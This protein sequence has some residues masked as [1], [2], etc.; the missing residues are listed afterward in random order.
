[1]QYYN[2]FKDSAKLTRESRLLSFHHHGVE[3]IRFIHRRRVVLTP[4]SH[5]QIYESMV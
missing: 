2:L 3:T 5:F 4:G 1:M